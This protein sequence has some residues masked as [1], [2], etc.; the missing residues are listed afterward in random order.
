LIY[1]AKDSNAG[2][3]RKRNNNETVKCNKK[4]NYIREIIFGELDSNSLNLAQSISETR[5]TC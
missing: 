4:G 5:D 3:S 2:F 1:I